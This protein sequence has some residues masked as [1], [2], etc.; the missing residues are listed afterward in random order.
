MV[1]KVILSKPYY[2]WGPAIYV[3]LWLDNMR[4]G[5]ILKKILLSRYTWIVAPI[6]V[7]LVKRVV[8][9]A[10]TSNVQPNE[11]DPIDDDEVNWG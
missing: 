8:A 5:K 3:S 9:V 2:I 6:L 1:Y 7:L 10:L 11:G 4:M